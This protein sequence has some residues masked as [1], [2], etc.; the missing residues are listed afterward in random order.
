ML[1]CGIEGQAVRSQS[2]VCRQTGHARFEQD[3][4]VADGPGN[5][6]EVP[7]AVVTRK[8]RKHC[9]VIRCHAKILSRTTVRSNRILAAF[10]PFALQPPPYWNKGAKNPAPHK[11]SITTKR[12]KSTSCFQPFTAIQQ[13]LRASAFYSLLRGRPLGV[14]P[15]R[16]LRTYVNRTANHSATAP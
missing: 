1:T 7:R 11:I 15:E 4:R 13:K 8:R 3:C 2:T 16:N 5:L 6:V 14:P 10:T 12:P 9:P